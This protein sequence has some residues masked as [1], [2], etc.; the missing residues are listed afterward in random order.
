VV[1]FDRG[2]KV[3]IWNIV[4]RQVASEFENVRAYACCARPPQGRMMAITGEHAVA[5]WDLY[6]KTKIRDL[7]GSSEDVTASAFIVNERTLVH[8]RENRH[9]TRV[10]RRRL[11][12]WRI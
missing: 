2:G 1:A 3:V 10:S 5:I 7:G 8:G 9:R 12:R 11:C 6:V 4:G